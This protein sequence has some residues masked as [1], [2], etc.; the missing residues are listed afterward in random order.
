MQRHEVESVRQGNAGRVVS[1]E[2]HGY[3]IVG[4]R[5]SVSSYILLFKSI[6]HVLEDVVVLHRPVVSSQLLPLRQ[7]ITDGIT[8]DT[9]VF[10]MKAVAR[11]REP[12]EQV[13]RVE[14]IVKRALRKVFQQ[15]FKCLCY[16]RRA[17]GFA[18]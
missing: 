12:I 3:E 14:N 8:H 5:L 11:G 2:K 15:E 1:S 13:S 9:K 4:K 10:G 17:Q 6:K 18:A 7:N 16:E